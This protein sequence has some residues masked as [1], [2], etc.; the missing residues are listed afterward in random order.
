MQ[1]AKTRNRRTNSVIAEYADLEVKFARL[2]LYAHNKIIL[3]NFPGRWTAGKRGAE[4]WWANVLLG[5]LGSS[6]H[7]QRERDWDSAR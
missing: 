2:Y 4:T 5:T 7:G 6:W 3:L 1:T